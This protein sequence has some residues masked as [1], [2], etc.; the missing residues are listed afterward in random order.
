MQHPNILLLVIDTLR[1]D[2]LGC[3]GC[4]DQ[5][6]E[7]IDQ[8]AHSSILFESA[9]SASNF[10]APAFASLFTSLY[11]A[12]HGVYDFKIKALPPSPLLEL[13]KSHGYYRKAV[14]DFGFFK[15]YLGESF[16]DMESLTDL[17]VNWSTEG[18]LV[19]TQRAIEW[20]EQHHTEPFFLFLHLSPPHTPYRFPKG[21]YE[22]MMRSDLFAENAAE[23]RS[24]ETL[25]PLFPE[26]VDDRIPTEQI[27]RYNQCSRELGRI[28]VDGNHASFV[29]Y[30]YSVEV[31]VVDDLVGA[32]VN[33][34]RT[35]GVLD[36]TIVSLSSD[37]GEE[38]W[39]HGSF[40]HGASAMYNEVIRTPWILSVPGQDETAGVVDENV[41]HVNILPTIIDLAGI[42]M[43]DE[44]LGRSVRGHVEASKGLSGA[45]EKPLPPVY[46]ETARLIS[47]V[48]GDYKLIT[49]NQRTSFRSRKERIRYRL[50]R[51]KQRFTGSERRALE[52]YDLRADPGEKRNLAK[53]RRAV[54][55][56][57]LSLIR[58][59][60]AGRGPAIEAARDLTKEEEDRIKKELEG[61]G[62]H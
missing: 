5:L 45:D 42:E 28:A 31:K 57:L 39:D 9:Y 30:L 34:L 3:Y 18:P 24:H 29:K 23:F 38:L 10:T 47:V 54:A 55:E 56:C 59:Y 49:P 15:S 17:T 22:N 37:H 51:I 60:H 32:V 44:Y 40:S 21:Y 4:P 7:N 48:D 11:P 41:S 61:L 13:L 8:I 33:T 14:V 20:L 25:G 2:Y 46:C 52:L 26:P 12:Q 35:L 53:E 16:D 36:N 6:S 43:P 58:D 50:G 19:E 62:Y 1:A 27:D